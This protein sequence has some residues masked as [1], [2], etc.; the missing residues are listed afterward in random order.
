MNRIWIVVGTV[1]VWLL[2]AA[3][4]LPA[5]A[6]PGHG[7]LYGTDASG[8]NLL[9]IDTFNGAGRVVGP[10]S[11][12]LAVPSLAT[13]PVART[14]YAGGGGGNPVVLRVDPCTGAGVLV[15][16]SGLG[17]AAI[18]GMDF[19]FTAPE[20][21]LLYASVNIAGDGGTGSDHLATIDTTTGLATVIGPYGVC[22]GVTLPSQGD[23]SCTIEGMETI[24][25]AQN[26]TLYG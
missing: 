12:G 10:I 3:C 18:G 19:Q 13:D 7:A 25:F 23:G 26:G 15:G 20:S 4:D 14:M 2:L 11:P 16:D 5:H 9:V 17:V 21:S 1:S 22:M 8:G 6:S 24:A